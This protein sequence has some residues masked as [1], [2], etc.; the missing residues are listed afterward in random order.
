MAIDPLHTRLVGELTHGRPL[1]GGR[2][3]PSGRFLFVSAEDN[4]IQRFDLLTGQKTPLVGHN[5]WLRG[6]AFLPSA[7][8]LPFAGQPLAALAGGMVLGHAAE[9][10]TPCTL[11]AGDYHGVLKWWDASGVTPTT[12][13]TVN[14]HDGWIRAVAVSPDGTQV[15][16]CGNDRLVKIWASS[17]G[18]LLQTLDGHVNHVYNVAFHPSGKNLVSADLKGVIK[19][20][21][22]ASGKS[23][24]E[25]DGKVFHKYDAGFGAD[26]G[27]IR[28]I[29][30]RGDGSL[31]AC[32]GITNVSNAFAGVGNPLVVTF[33]WKDGKAKQL[34]PKDAFQG[35][36]WGV[37][38]HPAGFIVGGGG[39]GQ[40]RLWFWKGEDTTSLHTVT[41]P[42]NTRDLALHPDG[43]LLAAL[44]S[45]G[46]AYL[47]TMISLPNPPKAVAPPPMKK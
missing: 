32:I 40:G 7:K 24:R 18:R 30:F 19:D 3:D 12:T 33:D 2:F 36:G 5:S 34:K 1:I 23:V 26:I 46:K 20:W 47:Y 22:L 35:T 28:G 44:A 16:S 39:G 25:L 43:S 9:Q 15:A 37:Y 10:G 4:T 6:M 13:R 45:N 11:I 21:D 29:H 42:A 27:G 8:T 31:L 38:C 17:D 41:V 14:A